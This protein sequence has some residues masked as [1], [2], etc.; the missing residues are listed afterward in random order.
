MSALAIFTPGIWAVSI[1][2]V[3]E[4]ILI[5]AEIFNE[6]TAFLARELLVLR[7]LGLVALEVLLIKFSG[8]D[9]NTTFG[10]SLETT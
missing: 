3:L 9:S 1:G 8:I 6:S 4:L 7:F 2:A 10:K 5:W